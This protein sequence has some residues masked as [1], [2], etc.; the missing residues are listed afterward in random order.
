MI[1]MNSISFNFAKIL[2]H[3]PR[4]ERLA[5]GY[6]M[7][8]H[9]NLMHHIEEDALRASGFTLDAKE[10]SRNI[11][12][13]WVFWWQGID[14]APSRVKACI[15]SIRRNSYGRQ[16][17]VITQ[18]NVHE[19]TSLPDYI[20]NK[21]ADGNIT[22]TH[23][24]DILR[25]NL[26]HLHGGIWMDATLYVA[27][28]LDSTRYSGSF[29]TC[30]GYS[31]PT[32]FN[33]SDGKWTG[34]FIGG[35]KNEP[36]FA[37]MNQ[38]FL[39]YWKHNDRLIDYFLIDYALEYAYDHEIGSLRSWCENE[40]GQDNPELFDLAPII[41]EPFDEEKWLE[42]TEKT[43]VFKL[44]WKKPASYPDGSFGDYL[45]SSDNTDESERI[46]Q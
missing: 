17:V 42:L 24:S 20:F 36:L 11:G 2:K 4:M 9:E 44:S 15:S 43:D 8:R 39:D 12:P 40:R 3:L 34:F 28:L 10:S 13:I 22:L 45:I 31:D 26:L 30:S 14:D 37:F 38:F 1:N 21:L 7:H 18:S 5:R 6:N 19:Y 35:C 27:K 29:F 33:V 25:F 32:F 41:S 23:F 46:A 16:V